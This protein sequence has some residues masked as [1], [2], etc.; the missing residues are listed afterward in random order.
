MKLSIPRL[1]YAEDKLFGFLFL[2]T[3]MIPL[4]FS[5]FNYEN[6]ELIKY[7]LLMVFVGAALWAGFGA[8]NSPA[9]LGRGGKLFFLVLFSFWFW[10]LVV[11]LFAWDKNYSFF[12]FYPR[13]DNGFLFYSLWALLILL[14]SFINLQQIRVLLKTLVFVSGLSAIWG[15]LQALG[16]GFY[17]GAGVDFFNRGVPSFFGNPNFV[18]MFVA[19]L[20]PVGLLFLYQS[21][22]FKQRIYYSVSIFF[23][24]WLLIILASRG[25]LLA[26]IAGLLTVVFLSLLFYKQASKSLLIFLIVIVAGIALGF[27]FLNIVRP[28]TIQSTL[29][30]SDVNVQDR[31][32]VWTLA[33]HSMA[34]RPLLGVGL[35]SFQLMFEHDRTSQ[36]IY[37]GFF[38]DAHNLPLELGVTGGLP[39]LALFLWLIVLALKSGL[40]QLT[41]DYDPEVIALVAAIAAWL[42]ASLFTPVDIP[43][44]VALAILVSACLGRGLKTKDF[45]LSLPKAAKKLAVVLGVVLILYGCT[46]FTA[47]T[48]FFIGGRRYGDGRFSLA[49]KYFTVAIWLNPVNRLYYVYQA[50]SAIRAGQSIATVDRLLANTAKINSRRA[51]SYVQ[52]ANLDYLLLYRTQNPVYRQP[53]LDNL[54]KAISRDPFSSNNYFLLAEYQMVFGDLD[55]AKLSLLRGLSLDPSYSDARMFL[56]K[57]YQLQGNRKALEEIL[58]AVYQTESDN[59]QLIQLWRAAQTVPDI[60]ALPINLHFDVGQLQ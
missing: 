23:Q 11:S 24:L 15:I 47:E 3:L 40:G 25:A 48:L 9:R 36:I 35:G 10:A 45:E 42:V 16:F 28:G 8:K 12:G 38:D 58:K 27:G 26:L 37:S 49:N 20:I 43:C 32:G 56:A 34:K 6:F 21:K 22:D 54:E 13:F 14:L 29:T 50:G 55:G 5:V 44:Y 53:I 59:I 31:W 60:R 52:A 39:L 41:K 7:A 51:Y 18:S 1:P 46:F 4:A 19:A 2:I 17:N 30:F 33:L 57:I